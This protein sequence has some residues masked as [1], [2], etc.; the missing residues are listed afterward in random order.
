MR[1]L[2]ILSTTCTCF[3]WSYCQARIQDYA[4]GH[5]C[6]PEQPGCG[7][8]GASAVGPS[9][10]RSPALQHR[11]PWLLWL[12]ITKLSQKPKLG[13]VRIPTDITFMF[14]H[15]IP[16]VGVHT[17][18]LYHPCQ[19]YFLSLLL[20]VWKTFRKS[21]NISVCFFEFLFFPLGV[22]RRR[23]WWKCWVALICIIVD[24]T[25]IPYCLVFSCLLNARRFQ[26]SPMH[27]HSYYYS[28]RRASERK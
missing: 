13:G 15:F 22:E 10:A 19:I 17:F 12:V 27:V 4:W 18:S 5:C 1:E 21:K 6:L 3:V 23:P 8:G 26:L 2:V 24:L 20:C 11:T 7:T 14:T 28:H 16:V 25:K 9:G